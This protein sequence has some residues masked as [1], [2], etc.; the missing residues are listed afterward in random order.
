MRLSILR[1]EINLPKYQI[2]GPHFVK[3]NCNVLEISASWKQVD[4]F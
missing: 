4:P 2:Q 3:Y 1:F